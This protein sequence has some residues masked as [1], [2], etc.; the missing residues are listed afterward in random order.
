MAL[1]LEQISNRKKKS[2]DIEKKD[3][4]VRPWEVKQETSQSFS[5]NLAVKRAREI[6]EKNNE[7]VDELRA[8]K[9]SVNSVNEVEN[10][11]QKREEK[12]NNLVSK[13]TDV[14]KIK[15]SRGILGR[16]KKA[17]LGH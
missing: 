4:P 2:V 8:Y 14:Q 6:V 17:F 16:F 11:I 5:G 13:T 15:T 12:F 3:R 7:M 9:S 10:Y 1:S